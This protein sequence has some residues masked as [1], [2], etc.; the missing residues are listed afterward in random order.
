MEE[1]EVVHRLLESGIERWGELATVLRDGA[2]ESLAAGEPVEPIRARARC[3]SV[4]IEG[5]R[6]GR[7]RPVDRQVLAASG[8]VSERFLDEVCDLAESLGG[9][10]DAL[11]QALEEGRVPGFL[12][13]KTADLAEYLA[14]EGYRDARAVLAP[15]TLRD[16]A[17]A[18]LAAEVRAGHLTLDALDELLAEVVGGSGEP[19]EP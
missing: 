14:D 4:L 12:S 11:V 17:L 13:R 5:W 8:A 15:E 3:V 19:A 6:I 18:A 16:R 2:G 7:G 9:S 10:A 1:V